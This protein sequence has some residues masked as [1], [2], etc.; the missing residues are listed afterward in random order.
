MSNCMDPCTLV[1]IVMNRFGV[2]AWFLPAAAAVGAEEPS[3][4]SHVQMA[5]EARAPRVGA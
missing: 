2:L 3:T 4:P 1:Q 5:L